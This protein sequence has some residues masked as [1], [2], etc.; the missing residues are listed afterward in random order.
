M[1]PLIDRLS[2]YASAQPGRRQ[3]HNAPSRLGHGDALI[4]GLVIGS[5]AGQRIM[6]AWRTTG[7]TPT[8]WSQTEVFRIAGAA[9]GVRGRRFR[10]VIF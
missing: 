1:T 10:L 8:S 7:R 6:P 9:V 5:A 3:G 4:A 2:A